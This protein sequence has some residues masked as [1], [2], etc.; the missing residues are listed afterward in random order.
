MFIAGVVGLTFLIFSIVFFTIFMKDSHTR[1]HFRKFVVL[2]IGNSIY[3]VLFG[4]LLN[5]GDNEGAINI[6]NRATLIA[7]MFVVVFFFMLLNSMFDLK[8][9]VAIRVFF[10][11]ATVFTIILC[12]DHPLILT[13]PLEQTSSFYKA[14]QRGIVHKIWGIFMLFLLVYSAF[15]LYVTYVRI[16]GK[17]KKY[18]N[19]VFILLIFSI[20][21][22]I[23][24]G[25]DAL[26]SMKILDL[27]PVSW[28]GS[29]SIVI[30]AAI[31]LL[32]SYEHLD[33]TVHRLYDELIH[34]ALTGAFSKSYFDIELNKVMAKLR[35]EP[36]RHYLVVFDIDDFKKIND[37]HGHVCG[38]FI[39][40]ELIK[41]VRDQLRKSDILARF[42]G[43]EFLLLVEYS[44]PD[45]D[46][47]R[48]MERILEAIH[49]REFVFNGEVI[50]VSCSFGGAYLDNK[51]IE[52][53]MSTEDILVLADNAVYE[54]K[55][56]GKDRFVLNTGEFKVN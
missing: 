10:S 21:W 29:M 2:T 41:T 23:S 43:D 50:Q 46:I 33:N 3:M 12:I 44:P 4:L 45:M 36:G 42:G 8:Q 15:F 6:L 54:A 25:I 13:T 34:D 47:Y 28:I 55:R 52:E 19:S 5:M 31:L 30:T 9:K 39:L 1:Q 24:G 18:K 22:V 49:G 32:N 14:L 51:V 7:S 17:Q 40:K 35:R 53:M 56:L 11:I 16:P 20:F 38:D 48:M 37:E 27:P 26:T